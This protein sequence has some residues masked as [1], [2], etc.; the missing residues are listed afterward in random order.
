MQTHILIINHQ[1]GFAVS[2]KQALERTGNFEVHPFTSLDP[3]LEYLRGHLQDV[4][5]V[6][7]TL[8]G[9]SGAEAVERL[10]QLQPALALIATPRQPEALLGEL[11]LQGTVNTPISAREIIP[12]VNKAIEGRRTGRLSST[13]PGTEDLIATQLE[14]RA[15][16][17]PAEA[18]EQEEAPRP[19]PGLLGKYDEGELL[20]RMATRPSTSKPPT[21]LPE[22]TSIDNVLSSV[23][24]TR[25]LSSEQTPPEPEDELF[26]PIDDPLQGFPQQPVP[27]LD[28]DA[29]NALLEELESG[30]G[31]P[32]PAGTE[33]DDLVNSMRTDEPHKPLPTRHQ[34][35]VEFILTG[36][37]DPLLEEIERKK[38]DELPAAGADV[39]SAAEAVVEEGPAPLP[40]IEDEA[41]D[42]GTVGDLFTGVSDTSFRNVLSILRGEEVVP[43]ETTPKAS[44]DDMREAFP[45]F[46]ASAPTDIDDILNEIESGAQREI[47]QT[48]D[49]GFDF[50]E[51]P[52]TNTAQ[53]I[54]ETALDESTPIGSFSISE[55]IHNIERQ[56][57][58]HRPK[59]QPLPSWIQEDQQ[60]KADIDRFVREPDFLPKVLPEFPA[61]EALPAFDFGEDGYDQTT[62]MSSA[63]RLE[64]EPEIME[65]EWLPA[66]ALPE[67]DAEAASASASDFE[68]VTIDRSAAEVDKEAA[69]EPGAWSE[70]DSDTRPFPLG[71]MQ[72]ALA[73]AEVEQASAEETRPVE[74]MEAAV[75]ENMATFESDV[76]EAAA[77]DEAPITDPYIAQLALSL[78]EV[79]LELTAEATLLT[80]A[81]QIVAYAGRMA[82]E[83]LDELR[84]VIG[85]DWD[86]N[87]D[88]ARIRF[89][90]LEG[91][92]KD[93]MLFSR[94]TVDDLTLSLVFSGTTPL[95][96]IR[97][98]GKRLVEALQAVPEGVAEPEP[99]P[100]DELALLEDSSL[101]ETAEDGLTR[102]PYAYVWLMR[103]PDTHLTNSVAQAIVRGMNAQLRERSWRLKELQAKEE[104]VYLL[105]DIPGETPPYDVI[106]DLKRR[107]ALIAHDLNPTLDPDTLWADSYLVVMPGRR[108]ESDEIQQF[109]QFERML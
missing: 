84:E 30:E 12:V 20:R 38:T 24:G 103:D 105:A 66:E 93:Y 68:N 72:A 36:G 5:L 94:R 75:I 54:L 109:I 83:E 7:F 1:L 4:A 89:I 104:Y 25:G 43:E 11:G 55:L 92:G 53:V 19:R 8:P 100:A 79:S 15:V 33:F 49:V 34:Q 2:I 16:E 71:E 35:F 41:V 28:E 91:S 37:M 6:D 32:P 77:P 67:A 26:E 58:E 9:V 87:P 29:F 21:D 107:A 60:R 63:Q 80:R 23:A 62:R 18:D 22:Y 73:A 3:A 47:T 50:D 31:A 56:L 14:Q 76:L 97:R 74:A 27:T 108:L 48:R 82:R 96:D 81:G 61:D 39:E 52:G 106:R 102:A 64:S 65:T 101:L 17:A 69:A 42:E 59:V 95:R 13:Q 57:P 40:E 85:G 90:N 70:T 99:E 78:T 45:Q 88:E 98:Q 51:P 86:A 10:R 46:F 44:A